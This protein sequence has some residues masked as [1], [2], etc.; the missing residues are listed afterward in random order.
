V[1]IPARSA[2]GPAGVERPDGYHHLKRNLSAGDA[3]HDGRNLMTS[4]TTEAQEQVQHAQE[5][6]RCDWCGAEAAHR[7]AVILEPKVRGI[8]L[9][10]KLYGVCDD[11]NVD[12]QLPRLQN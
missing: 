5:L 11:C 7:H 8:S 6:G 10:A 4:T 1:V 12:P 9:G 3:K 2:T